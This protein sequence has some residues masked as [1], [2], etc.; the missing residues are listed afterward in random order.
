MTESK[1]ALDSYSELKL[2][3]ELWNIEELVENGYTYDAL[4]EIKA[5]IEQIRFSEI[6]ESY[7][8]FDAMDEMREEDILDEIKDYVKS[9]SNDMELGKKIRIYVNLN[10]K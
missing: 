10:L 2:L 3:Q 7:T 9:E 1:L 4:N 8:L 5:L 6:I